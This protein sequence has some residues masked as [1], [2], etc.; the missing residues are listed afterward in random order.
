MTEIH[1]DVEQLDSLLEGIDFCMLTTVDGEGRLHSR[2]MSTQKFKT[3]GTLYFLTDER[4]HK[5][6][7]IER[8]PQVLVAYAQPDDQTYLSVHGTARVYRDEALI[9][10]LWSPVYRAWWPNGR[11]DPDIRVLAVDV[12]RV[13][14]WT[15]PGS[16]LTQLVGFAKAVVGKGSGEDLGEQGTIHP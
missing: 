7:D 16:K 2:P 6:D 13:D 15:S 4:S 12:D 5:V 10:E 8:D 1:D 9:R 11:H 14:Y 3:D